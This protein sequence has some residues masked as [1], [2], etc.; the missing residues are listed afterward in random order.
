[1]KNIIKKIYCLSLIGCIIFCFPNISKAETISKL[2]K[3]DAGR[4][5]HFG[6]NIG[7]NYGQFGFELVG[8]DN[9]MMAN[10][11][12]FRVSKNSQKKDF[13]IMTPTYISVNENNS[14]STIRSTYITEGKVKL[15]DKYAPKA[16]ERTITLSN[17][18]VKENTDYSSKIVKNDNL[19]HLEIVIDLL[20]K[21]DTNQWTTIGKVSKDCIP[22]GKYSSPDICTTNTNTYANCRIDNSGNIQINIPQNCS[23]VNQISINYDYVSE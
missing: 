21:F 19:T 12:G 11:T 14:N 10:Y 20:T 16:K 1:M 3:L 17:K 13:S 6:Q 18:I 23:S 22:S 7:G 2:W 15:K 5:F 9:T 8:L 4:Y